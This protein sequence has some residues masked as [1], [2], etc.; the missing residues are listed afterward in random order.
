MSWPRSWMPRPRRTKRGWAEEQVLDAWAAGLTDAEI[1]QLEHEAA[2]DGY[3][4]GPDLANDPDTGY[5]AYELAGES[6]A[7]LID[8]ALASMTDREHERQV[9]D[10]A[11]RGHRRASTEVRLSNALGRVGAGSYLYGQQP[12]ELANAL[13]G[14]GWADG[15]FSTGPVAGPSDVRAELAYQLRGG[16]APGRARRQPMPP[17]GGLATR[18][19]LR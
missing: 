15:Q 1:A 11:E 6:Q 7:S 14:P 16:L 12:A 18:I 3:G 5:D 4:S 2:L 8:A 10:A 9:Q 17:V 13:D 19:G